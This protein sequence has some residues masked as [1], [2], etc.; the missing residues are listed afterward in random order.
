MP[1]FQCSA[2]RS[3]QSTGNPCDDV[4]ERGRIFR[5]AD[6]SAVFLL[7]E[8]L[9]STVDPEMDWLREVFD[10][11]RPVRAFMLFHSDPACVRDRRLIV[12]S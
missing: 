4:I 8:V 1:H 11:G 5:A 2:K 7:V 3:E 12:H 9:D 6:F 10:Q